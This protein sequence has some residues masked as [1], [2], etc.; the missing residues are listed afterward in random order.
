MMKFGGGKGSSF[1]TW[2]KR[3]YRENTVNQKKKKIDLKRENWMDSLPAGGSRE[4]E[5]Y[6]T[7]GGRKRYMRGSPGKLFKDRQF[8]RE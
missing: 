2:R 5:G 8:G 3:V 6:K 1:R 7:K 4:P